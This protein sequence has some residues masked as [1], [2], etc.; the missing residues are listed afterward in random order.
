MNILMNYTSKIRLFFSKNISILG[1]PLRIN[2]GLSVSYMVISAVNALIT[3]VVS[4]YAVALFVDYA[5]NIINGKENIS[6]IYLPLG[7]MMLVLLCTNMVGPLS[8]IIKNRLTLQINQ[9]CRVELLNKQAQLEY[10]NIEDK[11]TYELINRV[12]SNPESRFIEG[13][14]AYMTV[15][16]MIIYVLAI[17]GIIVTRVWW[18]A[19]LIFIFSVP[20]V[21]LAL[22][23]GKRNYEAFIDIEKYQRQ[24]YYLESV[25][26]DREAIDERTV[27]GF[28]DYLSDRWWGLYQIARTIKL[29]VQ[30]RYMV[31]TKGSTIGLSLITVFVAITLLPSIINGKM[32]PGMYMGLIGTVLSVTH[33]MGWDMSA[34][35]ETIA[36]SKEFI[37][38]YKNFFEL[39]GQ[40]EYIAEPC[41]ASI[42]FDSLEFKNV[43]FKYPKTEEYVLKNLSFRIENGKRYAFVG[44][45]GTGKT[46]ITKLLMGLYTDYDGEIYINDIE[47]RQYSKAVLKSIFS[48]IQQDFA[49]YAIPLK[50]NIAL[51]NLARECDLNDVSMILDQ[52]GLSDVLAKSS[53]DLDMHLGKIHADGIEISTGQ[54]QRVAIARALY[55]NAPIK[56]LDEPTAALDPISEGKLYSEF[57]KL[58]DNKTAILISHRLGS[59]KIIDEIMVLQNGSIAEQGTHNELMQLKGLYYKM[60]EAQRKWYQ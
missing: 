42:E 44:S 56:I 21:K 52:V 36:N 47:L 25:L 20:M 53:G 9:T 4:T 8:N 54:W 59:T 32:T 45:N 7:L 41:K 30:A 34:A 22:L 55:S 31:L 1:V 26:S 39:E 14:Q 33:Q 49:R 28:S 43:S 10:F 17:L 37:K 57:D 2:P 11:E 29:K 16:T 12:I 27:F 48:I 13:F 35:V 50:D 19:L 38:E 18:A 3:S 15:S 51:G 60:F 23:S 40:E 5:L 46:T 58:M 24:V 6:R